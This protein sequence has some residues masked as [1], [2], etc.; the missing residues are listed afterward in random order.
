MLTIEQLRARAAAYRRD[1]ETLAELGDTASS[2]RL[3]ESANAFDELAANREA[4]PVFFIEIE[5]DDWIN[6]GRIESKNRPD[7]GLLPDGINLL[8]AAPPAPANTHPAAWEMR[9]WNSGYNM[10]HDWERI[11]AEQHAEMSVQHAADNDYE[12]R[13]L[14]D[15]PPAPAV[16]DEISSAIRHLKDTLVACNRFNYCADAVQRVENACRAAMLKGDSK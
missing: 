13:V 6:A 4:Q 14:Y 15:A 16:P 11:T 3:N 2:Q 1:A 9:H 12:F 5:G 10:W 8:Y 7:L